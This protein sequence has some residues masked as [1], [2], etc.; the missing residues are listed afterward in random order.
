M[1]Q[2]GSLPASDE[3][4]VVAGPAEGARG[5]AVRNEGLKGIQADLMEEV[6]AGQE[7]RAS[8]SLMEL[9]ARGP[10]RCSRVAQRRQADGAVAGPPLGHLVTHENMV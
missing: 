4:L 9:E 3:L 2:K 5:A 1:I 6:G 10:R 8:S 7:H